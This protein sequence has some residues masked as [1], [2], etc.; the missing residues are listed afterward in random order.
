MKNFFTSLLG[1][2][3]A[4]VIFAGGCLL[5]FIGFI[6][7][8]AA[9]GG[10]DKASPDLERGSYLVVDMSTN[11][12]DSPPPVDLSAFGGHERTVQLRTLTRSLRAA[13]KDEK[14]AGVFL[15]GDLNAAAFGSGYAALKEVRAALLEFKASGKPITAYLTYATTK[16]YYLASAAS[17]L[18]L[19]PYG[20]ILMPGLA[21]EPMFYAGAFEK[22]GIGV[23]VTRVGK[24]KSAVE[25]FTRTA[26]STENRE[27]LQKLLGDLWA[28]I[29]ADIAPARGASVAEIQATVDAEGIIR[30]EPAKAAG[31]VDRIAYRDEIYDGLKAK[32]GRAGSKETFKQITLG[33][34]AKLA[35]DVV[36]AP[37]KDGE[38]SKFSGRGRIAV[39]YAD[40]RSSMARA[41]WATWAGADFRASCASSGRT[42]R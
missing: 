35:K 4:L 40:G 6:G 5:L 11:I 2:L 22:Y 15:T 16:G 28:D 9:M 18:A 19:D 38:S 21:T 14:I 26:M 31:L 25:P 41:M 27:E 3:A 17:D 29:L 23:Q 24:Y 36:D 1:A 8:I 13:A 20:M 12:T 42:R 37:K 39:V 7:V 34:Y 32:T 10:G 30:P 33:D